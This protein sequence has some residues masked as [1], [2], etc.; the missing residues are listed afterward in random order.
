MRYR[1]GT[2]DNEGRVTLRGVP[3]GSY[4]A[5]AWES[6]PETAWLNKE[7]LAKYQA[8]GMAVSVEPGGQINL[9]LR[10]NPFDTDLR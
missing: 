7:F 4:T 5:F 1:V 10:W 3:P 8:Q 6:I 9:Q 2:T